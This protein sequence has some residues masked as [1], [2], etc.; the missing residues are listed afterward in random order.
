MIVV[1]TVVPSLHGAMF[2]LGGHLTKDLGL[3]PL[4][5]PPVMAGATGPMEGT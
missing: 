3:L 1:T 2:A 5:P 4:A